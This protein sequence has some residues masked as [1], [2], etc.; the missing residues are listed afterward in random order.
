MKRVEA[1]QSLSHQHHNSLMACLLLKK[2]IAKKAGEFTLNDFLSK[3]FREDIEPHFEAE[4]KHLF[5]LVDQLKPEYSN[6]L[7]T[8]H[9]LL[10]VLASRFM[11]QSATADYL[12]TYASLLEDHI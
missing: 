2:G 12:K 1:L 3:F 5:P 10:R 8:D 6:I 9:A 4:E 7:R 11:N